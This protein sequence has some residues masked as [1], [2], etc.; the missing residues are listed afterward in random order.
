MIL[1]IILV[2]IIAVIAWCVASEGAWGAALTLVAVIVS[3]LLAMNFFEATAGFL[4]QNLFDSYEWQHRWDVIALVGL[5]AGFVF[6]FRT[7]AERIMPVHIELHGLVYDV[8]RWVCSLAAG[9]VTMAFLLTALHTA[10]LPPDTLGFTAEP[11]RR[12][13]PLGQSAPDMKW[14]GFVQ[15]MSETAFRSG[16]GPVFDGPRFALYP[17]GDPQVLP[18]FPIRYASRRDRYFGGAPA[19]A[20]VSPSPAP[21]RAAGGTGRPSAPRF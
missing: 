10:P 7:A 1:D 8:G 19:P 9:Y 5:F 17:G 12:V 6:A 16:G 18:T 3:G 21:G 2:G 14:L 13:G 11:Q 4:E 20:A 15:H